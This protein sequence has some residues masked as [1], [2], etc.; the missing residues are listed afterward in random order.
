[1]LSQA[2]EESLSVW[3][4]DPG[5]FIEEDNL[6]Y[7]DTSSRNDA[8]SFIVEV[9]SEPKKCSPL[10]PASLLSRALTMSEKMY[11]ENYATWWK[12]RE[13]AF[14]VLFKMNDT[15]KEVFDTDILK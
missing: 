1:M 12:L 9:H 10:T 8:A 11:A 2:S 5:V 4:S 15:P 6:D 14:F 7:G 3:Q 13:A